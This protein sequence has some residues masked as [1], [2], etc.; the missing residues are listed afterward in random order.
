MCYS[1]VYAYANF[2]LA[3]QDGLKSKSSQ[4]RYLKGFMLR[5]MIHIWIW[6]GLMW[7]NVKYNKKSLY[8]ADMSITQT[9][10]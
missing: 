2:V 7:A 6:N 10:A 4:S 9:Q 3:F 8:K 5:C 1:S